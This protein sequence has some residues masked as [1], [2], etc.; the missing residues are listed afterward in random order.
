MGPDGFRLKPQIDN[1]IWIHEKLANG[2]TQQRFKDFNVFAYERLGAAGLLVGLNNDPGGPRTITVATSFGPHVR[3]HDYTGHAPDAV[4][5]GAG[6]VTITIPQNRNGLSYVCYSGEGR[7]GGACCCKSGRGHRHAGWTRSRKRDGRVRDL[8]ALRYAGL[9]RGSGSGY[10]ASSGRTT[11]SGQSK[12]VRGK[13]SD[14]CGSEAGHHRLDQ[15]LVNRRREMIE[16]RPGSG[17]PLTT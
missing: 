5:D 17:P 13:H 9:R 7:D 14:K 11:R 8:H 2:P 3:L 16:A 12:L 1:L 4:T 6:N 15:C 10:L